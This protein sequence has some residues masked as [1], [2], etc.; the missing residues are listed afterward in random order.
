M[1]YSRL[2]NKYAIAGI[3]YTPQGKVPGRTAAS[4]HA[5]ACINAAKDAG[6]A[7]QE[8][9]GLLLYRHFPPVGEDIETTAF[10]VA[11]QL[12]IQPAILGQE[13]YCTRN[14]LPQAIGLLESGLCNYVLIS[15]GDNA[16]SGK[17]S[18]VKEVI[19]EQAT[20]EL[21]AYGDMS[22][23]AKYAMLARRAEYEFGTGAHVWKEIALAQRAWAQLNPIAQMH[24]KPLTDEQYENERMVVEPFRLLDATP[25][26]DGGRAILLTSAKNAHRLKQPPV[27][28]SGIGFAN[29]PESPYRHV[30]GDPYSAAAVAAKQA[31]QMAGVTHKDIDACELYDCFTYTVESLLVDYG[32]CKAN[33]SGAFI[34]RGRIGPGGALPVNTSGGMLSEAYFMGMTAICEAAMQLMGRAGERQ[35]G[36]R[37]GTKAPKT[38]VCGDNGGV[39]QSHCT[40]ILSG[41]IQV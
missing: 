11:E 14:G 17:R 16:R 40:L 35:L 29:R 8:V 2:K 1:Q 22:T 6:V 21:A 27:Y 18:F 4:F 26:S 33:E 5:Q 28:I 34:T 30:P 15:Y 24:G 37:T 23:L 32:F 20:D 41:G 19:G 13:H 38:I 36:E 10:T 31:F 12:G 9:D 39:F 7:L 3:G 25:V